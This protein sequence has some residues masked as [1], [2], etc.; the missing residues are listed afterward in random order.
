[1][2]QTLEQNLDTV[3]RVD[4]MLVNADARRN[5][6]LREIDQPPREF[7]DRHLRYRGGRD[8]DEN[9]DRAYSAASFLRGSILAKRTQP[10]RFR[11]RQLRQDWVILE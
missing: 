2:A 5:N 6:A 9:R 4:R 10:C 8:R 1:M 11:R 3:E 7:R